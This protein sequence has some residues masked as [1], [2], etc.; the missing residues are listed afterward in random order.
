MAWD[1]FLF[2]ASQAAAT[3]SDKSRV[4]TVSCLEAAM[5]I[6]NVSNN[7]GVERGGDRPLRADGKRDRSAATTTTGDRAA[8]SSDGREA[9][10][11]FDAS[12]E[13]AK[14]AGDDRASMVARAMEKLISGGLDSEVALR[15]TASRMLAAEFQ[16]F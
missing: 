2:T 6:R 7:G 11:S 9:K 4:G 5:N 3:S 12:V 16:T 1:V 14:G 13:A 15:D 10:A 8:I